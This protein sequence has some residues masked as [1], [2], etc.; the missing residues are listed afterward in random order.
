VRPGYQEFLGQL[1]DQGWFSAFSYKATQGQRVR[2][3]TMVG[4]LALV[5]S[6]IWALVSHRTLDRMGATDWALNIPFTSVRTIT[7][8]GDAAK[9]ELLTDADLNTTL[10]EQNFRNVNS[11][12]T[13]DFL[14]IDK[15]NASDFAPGQVVTKAEFEKVRADLAA[16][17]QP[18]PTFRSPDPIEGPSASRTLTLLPQ[19]RF[20][21]PLLLGGLGLWLAWRLVNFPAFADFLIATEA[22]LNKVSWTTRKRLIQDTI[23]V[24]ATVF[25]LT[26][27]LFAVDILWGRLLSW[28]PIGV[29]KIDTTQQTQGPQEQPW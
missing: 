3:A 6:G 28:K 18:T 7:K 23:V 11:T 20:A 16:R 1:E 5:A 17:D 13:R 22:E 19:V 14:R 29:L 25:L 21:L 12:L 27:F 9:A 24:L 8:L 4:I 15:P 2:R 26:V 10:G